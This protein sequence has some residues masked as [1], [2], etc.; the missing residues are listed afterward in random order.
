MAPLIRR[1]TPA[2]L[3]MLLATACI[4]A[5]DRPA[6][7]QRPAPLTPPRG[8]A[9]QASRRARRNEPRRRLR[10][11]PGAAT[12]GPSPR[13][14]RRSLNGIAAAAARQQVRTVTPSGGRVAAQTYVVKSGDTLRGISDKTGAASEAIAR[15][16]RI[17][18]PF[19]ILVGQKLKIPGGRYHK[20]GK[21]ETGI[22]I[23]RAY[24]VEWKRIAEINDLEEP[25][26]LR[27][28]QRLLLPSQHEVA[29]MSADERAAAFRVDIE[30]LISGS[31]PA[32]ATSEQPAPPVPTAAKP[33]A[34]TVAVAEPSRFDGRFAWPVRGPVLRGFGRYS[35]G[36]INQGINIGTPRG[37]P[38]AAAADGVVA[39]VGQ[40]IPAYGTL[41]LLR[42]GDGWISAYGYADSITVTRGQKVVKGQTIA[43]SG[44]SPYTPEPQLH[45]EIRSGLKPVNP[46]SYLPSRS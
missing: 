23:A 39:Y 20:V 38:I 17:E 10:A 18:P 13:R 30:D 42:H 36:Q 7:S 4:P 33:V 27:D 14:R 2:L 1:S 35:S 45:F 40:D 34:P 31:E 5:P 11:H 21:G 44:S 6:P 46:L 15:I 12:P 32:L 8:D 29:S 26:I 41:V 16:N 19:K 9:A 37:T 3:V 43:K 28:G 25:Y 22:A 24:G